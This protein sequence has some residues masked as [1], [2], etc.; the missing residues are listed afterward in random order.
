MLPAPL[1]PTLALARPKHKPKSLPKPGSTYHFGPYDWQVLKVESN[2]TLLIAKDI[3]KK[4]PYNTEFA[5]VTWETCTLRGWLNDVFLATFSEKDRNRIANTHN[6]DNQ[7]FGIK[8]GN[9]TKDK[10]F[11]LSIAEVVE[12]FWDSGQLKNKNP[13]SKFW[14]D[15]NYNDKRKAEFDNNGFWWWLRS[16]GYSPFNATYIDDDGFVIL[17]GRI[18]DFEGGL[19]SALWLNL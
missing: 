5:G 11:L 18:I 16:P 2:R 13:K 8:G 4:H 19:R 6:Q 3:I 15:D 10:V 12:C 14:I 17:Y 9:S 7:W 1:S